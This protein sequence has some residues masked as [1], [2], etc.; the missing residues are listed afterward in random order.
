MPKRY[1]VWGVVVLVLVAAA[2]LSAAPTRAVDAAWTGYYYPNKDLQGEPIVRQDPVITFDWGDR[3]PHDFPWS[4]DG[5]SVRWERTDYFAATTYVFAAASDDGVRMYLD[6]ELIIDEWTSRQASWTTVERTLTAGE[7]RVVVEYYED[8]GRA[9]IQ[10]G[11]Y[12][13]DGKPPAAPTSTPRPGTT[14][15]SGGS[16][17]S[18]AQPTTTPRPTSTP[19]PTPTAFSGISGQAA[20]AAPP[21]VESHRMV[22]ENSGKLFAWSGFPG[23]V[24]RTTGHAGQ[25]SY[26]KNRANKPTF[27]VRWYYQFE[28]AGFYDAYVY[29]PDAGGNPTRSA[30]YRV[31]H[32]NG[33]SEPI[34][35]D[36]AA[37]RGRWVKLGSFY[38][39][40]TNLQ[41]VYLSNVTGEPTSSR[42]VLL[43]A[44]M[45]VFAP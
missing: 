6:G 29:I 40:P 25:H 38:F 20:E 19:R 24:R 11:Y 26:V 28:E 30:V 16:G 7:H 3:P 18:G 31:F 35:V 32:A 43:D 22:E 44:V 2:A 21:P 10:A 45:F 34:V 33:L 42:E 4:G 41:Y 9:F 15:S 12:R 5:F 1:L 23:P 36:Q 14:P 27:E 17:G 39:L 37:N 13:K 8:T